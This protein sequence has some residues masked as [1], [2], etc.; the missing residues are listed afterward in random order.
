LT[1]ERD[2][3]ARSAANN[4]IGRG[5]E[6]RQVNETAAPHTDHNH[7]GVPIGGHSKDL[8]IRLAEDD[9]FVNATTGCLVLGCECMKAPLAL[10]HWYRRN[11]V[12]YSGESGG[13][14]MPSKVSTTCS[15]SSARRT[16]T[17]ANV[18]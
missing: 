11:A 15:P 18:K 2:D 7:I 12:T 6:Q 9:R 1:A 10:S 4:L 14:G 5:S 8:L 13:S 17:I 16:R 3:W